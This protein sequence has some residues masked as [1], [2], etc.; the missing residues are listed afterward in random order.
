MT[1]G[2][3]GDTMYFL[4]RGAAQAEVAAT[5]AGGSETAAPH[6][7][8]KSSVVMRWPPPPRMLAP[9][10]WQ[11]HSAQLINRTARPCA[12]R[13]DRSWRGPSF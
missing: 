8:G 13:P 4:E 2:E 6:T 11:R 10:N 7:G 12:P 1:Q 5:D 3:R 9:L